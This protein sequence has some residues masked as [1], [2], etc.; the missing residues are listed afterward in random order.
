MSTITRVLHTPYSTGVTRETCLAA[1]VPVRSLRVLSSS[2]CLIVVSVSSG[3]VGVVGLA[4]SDLC[5]IVIDVI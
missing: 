4:V 1:T 3:V 5:L 2:C